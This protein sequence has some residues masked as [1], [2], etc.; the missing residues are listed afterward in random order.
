MLGGTT[1]VEAGLSR[2]EMD[3]VDFFGGSGLLAL[4]EDPDW[5]PL[6]TV[7]LDL[8]ECVGFSLGIKSS[9]KIEFE[10]TS[11]NKESSSLPLSVDGPLFALVSSNTQRS[12]ILDITI[13]GKNVCTVV[14]CF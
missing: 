8:N 5:N 2:E 9:S 7:L 4:S 3:E 10:S 6:V 14:R 13:R 12:Q 11:F 1:T